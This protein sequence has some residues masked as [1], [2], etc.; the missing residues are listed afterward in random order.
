MSASRFGVFGF[1]LMLWG[2]S[3]AGEL[4]TAEM[5]LNRWEGSRG[6]AL[7]DTVRTKILSEAES[8]RT[9]VQ[10]EPDLR[11]AYEDSDLANALKIYLDN[12]LSDTESP[13]LLAIMH[14]E[15]SPGGFIRS[16]PTKYPSLS[17]TAG[18]DMQGMVINND[19]VLFDPA[20]GTVKVL[21]EIGRNGVLT[22][23]G[24]AKDCKFVIEA[25]RGNNYAESCSV[26]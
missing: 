20:R 15:I 17:V 1:A 7:T 9:R 3:H 22:V 2:C 23:G 16:F 12:Q 25:E 4:S 21:L 11:S 10:E 6:V 18:F 14:E 8:A 13:S 26:Q 19:E 24:G 5:T